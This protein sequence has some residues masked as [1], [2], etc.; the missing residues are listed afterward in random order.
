MWQETKRS[1]R[2]LGRS[3][4]QA[5]LGEVVVVSETVFEEITFL[6]LFLKLVH[7]SKILLI[8]LLLAIFKKILMLKILVNPV[9]MFH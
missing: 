6:F 7:L 2:V 5:E 8:W 1:Q 3:G 4:A 9:F